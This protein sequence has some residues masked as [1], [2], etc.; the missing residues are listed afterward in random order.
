MGNPSRRAISTYSVGNGTSNARTGSFRQL[1]PI[2]SPSEISSA[3]DRSSGIPLPLN[4]F[5]MR[6]SSIDLEPSPSPLMFRVAS[7]TVSGDP[8]L[9]GWK[10]S[11]TPGEK[12]RANEVPHPSDFFTDLPPGFTTHESLNEELRRKVVAEG[13]RLINE[14]S[15]ISHFKAEEAER[16]LF[17]FQKEVEEQS[18]RQAELH[19]RAL[20]RAE[21]KGRRTIVAEMKRR[22]L[23]LPPIESFKDAQ[24][25]S[26]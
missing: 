7:E 4:G 9:P 17:W 23:C 12:I 10:P 20:V 1:L 2:F 8:P 18:Q 21:R 25:L 26:R 14:E 6:R 19:S 11:F 13:S 5:E 24:E 15:R 22:A 16:E 3:A